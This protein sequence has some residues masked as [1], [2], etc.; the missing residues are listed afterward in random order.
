MVTIPK[1]SRLYLAYYIEGRGFWTNKWMP[2]RLTGT[3]ATFTHITAEKLGDIL[4]KLEIELLVD[5]RG[6]AGDEFDSMMDCTHQFFARIRK[7]SLSLSAKKSEFFM[8]SIIF[9]GVR[10]G[11]GGVQPDNTKLTAVV[12][13]CKLPDLLNL[14]RFLGLTGYFRD[15]VKGYAKIAQPLTDLIRGAAI[16]RNAGKA[17]YRAALQKIKLANVWGPTQKAAFLSLKKVLTSEPVLKAPRFDGTPFIM[18]SDG[19][20]DSFGGM[21]AQNFEET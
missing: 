18:T 4:P 14:S 12:D 11:P 16:P 19:C 21:L 13:W 2:F 7:T 17:V 15:L 9:A 20:Q 6:M 1:E 10:V 8:T 3:P 5:D